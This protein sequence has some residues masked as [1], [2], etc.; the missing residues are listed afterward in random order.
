ML[1][2]SSNIEFASTLG[3]FASASLIPN[4]TPKMIANVAELIIT[5]NLLSF[6]NCHLKMKLLQVMEKIPDAPN[7][8]E[9]SAHDTIQ[10]SPLDAL[11]RVP[12]YLDRLDASYRRNLAF[13][14]DRIN[15]QLY[16]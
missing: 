11:T 12:I 2:T 6:T 1:C 16:K 8:E 4:N 3:I 15:R 7:E 14:Q 10:E 5:P 9:L 13:H